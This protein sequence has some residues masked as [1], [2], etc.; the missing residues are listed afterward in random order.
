MLTSISERLDLVVNNVICFSVGK[1]LTEFKSRRLRT[2]V[3]SLGP[4]DG[5]GYTRGFRLPSWLV[6]KQKSSDLFVSQR[7][8]RNGFMLWSVPPAPPLPNSNLA[9][10]KK[11]IRVA[12][13]S[14]VSPA[15]L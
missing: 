6:V 7:W 11:I 13:S 2:M 14:S 10:F 4:R 1:P 9:G 3:V 8:L 15:V 12:S 5:V